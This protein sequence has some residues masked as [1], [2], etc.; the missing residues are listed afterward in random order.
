MSLRAA[1]DV[2]PA[3]PAH[4]PVSVSPPPGSLAIIVPS[5]GHSWAERFSQAVLDT[6]LVGSLE[7]YGEAPSWEDRW[8]CLEFTAMNEPPSDLLDSWCQSWD[9]HVLPFLVRGSVRARTG[10]AGAVEDLEYAA[11]LDPTNPIPWG[12]LLVAARTM[13]HPG[14]D[15]ERFLAET[16]SRSALYQPHVEFLLALGSD[17]TRTDLM[18]DFARSVSEVVPAGSP[19]HAL[20]P[21]AALESMILHQ[22]DDHIEH[23]R[24]N[25]LFDDVLMAAGQSV[26]HPGFIAEPSV[27]AAKA[28][29]TFVV[30]LSILGQDDLGLLLADRIGSAVTDWPLSLLGSPTVSTWQT[31]HDRL[32]DK[33]RQVAASRS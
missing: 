16:V 6:D 22:P 15:I 33:G 25:G 2:K 7:V 20:V 1:V 12:Q 24:A 32:R 3:S 8:F 31:L 27:P 21:I 30:A 4:A 28:M 11:S 10:Q 17:S 13:G 23:L 5:L 19:L 18:I 29:N 14:A 26:F 9:A